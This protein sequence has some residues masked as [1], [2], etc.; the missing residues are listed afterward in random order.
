MAISRRYS[1][2]LGREGEVP[3]IAGDVYQ[4]ANVH[5]LGVQH[6]RERNRTTVPNFTD[7]VIWFLC[8]AVGGLAMLALSWLFGLWRTLAHAIGLYDEKE[9]EMPTWLPVALSLC[10]YVVG[11]ALWI[12]AFRRRE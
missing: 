3:P 11:L 8:G 1:L 12:A 9:K 5:V 2:P 7:F 10:T 6:L 4:A